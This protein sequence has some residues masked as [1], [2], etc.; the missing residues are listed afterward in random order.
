MK[1]VVTVLLLL[2]GGAAWMQ[3]QALAGDAV[4][5]ESRDD[6]MASARA[7]RAARRAFYTAP[8]VIPHA[9]DAR[10]TDRE[11][12]AC[13]E[14]PVLREGKL[15]PA[16][17]HPKMSNCQQCHVQ[18]LY[19]GAEAFPVASSWRGLEAPKPEARTQPLAPPT[20]PH[21]IFLRED[22][23]TC[24]HPQGPE[25]ALRTSHPD[26]S[27]CRQCHVVDRQHDF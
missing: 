15:T 23:L 3:V 2:L 18:G 9:V 17:P 27:N 6:Q 16:T 21:R 8:P 10:A 26:R 12:L 22:C 1:R 5:D 20:I 4:E 11:C 25:P 19:E 24:H 14:Q 7:R 13:H